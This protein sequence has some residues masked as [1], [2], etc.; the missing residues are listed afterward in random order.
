MLNSDRDKI[1]AILSEGSGVSVDEV[2]NYH[3]LAAD[4]GLE[5]VEFFEFAIDLEDEFLITISDEKLEQ[6][7]TVK[8]LVDMVD[9]LL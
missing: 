1:I 8:D 3:R 2:Q 6:C 7:I 9:E 5:A 4:L